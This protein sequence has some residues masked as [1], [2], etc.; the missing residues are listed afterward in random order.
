MFD[1]ETN[2]AIQYVDVIA[3]VRVSVDQTGGGG[4]GGPSMY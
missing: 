2:Q 3:V 1:L 4:G